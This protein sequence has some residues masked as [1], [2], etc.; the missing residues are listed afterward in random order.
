[1][2]DYTKQFGQVA[3]VIGTQY[4]DEGKGKIVDALSSSYDIIA[5]AAGGA[6][7]GHTIIIDGQKH[8]FHLLASGVLYEHVNVVLGAGMVIHLDT[9]LEEIELLNESGVSIVDRLHISN[10][11]HIVMDYHKEID[12]WNENFRSSSSKGTIG[13][14]KRGIGPA[15]AD[16]AYR[17]GLRMEILREPDTWEELLEFRRK[18]VKTL[19]D[20]DVDV[21]KEMSSIRKAAALLGDR[22]SDTETYLHNA[23]RDGKSILVEGAQAIMLDIDHGSYPFVTSSATTVAGALQGLGL[24]PSYLDSTIGVVKAY[25]TRV[26]NGNFPTELHGEEGER[27]QKNGGEFG[28]T[29]GRPRRCGWLNLK[30]LEYTLRL[31][32]VTHLALT[33]LDVL[34][35]EKVIKIATDSTETDATYQDFEGWQKSSAGTQDF[36]KLPAKAQSYV[37]FI[38][39]V[40]KKPVSFIGTGP[41]RSELVTRF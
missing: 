31:N 25:C 32:G 28:A 1:M 14:T 27:L 30:D 10:K 18:R 8:V 33:K 23:H 12:A 20:L 22:V 15:Y 3:A 16:K 11:A 6:N 37:S 17:V 5:R 2:N 26:G 41:E 24:P 29:T 13:T 40:T 34:D 39:K 19:F 35:D 4:G 21:E 9:L 38:E 7:A 36:E